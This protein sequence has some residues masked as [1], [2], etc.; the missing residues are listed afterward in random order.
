[1]SAD[2]MVATLVIDNH[3][4]PD[5]KAGHRTIERLTAKDIEFPNEYADDEPDT[6]EGLARIRA[7]LAEDLDQLE[8]LLGD[9]RECDYIEVRGAVVY[10][11]G[12]PTYEGKSTELFERIERLQAVKGVL[13][14]V[15][16]ESEA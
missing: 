7:A 5:F 10:M 11:T 12:G 3:R 16:F 8:W 1:M 13:A 9:S 4:K 15:G 6:P 2:L 14:A